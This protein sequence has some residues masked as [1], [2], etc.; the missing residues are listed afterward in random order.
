MF[1][2][3]PAHDLP[4]LVKTDVLLFFPP[5]KPCTH[6]SKMQCISDQRNNS[7]LEDT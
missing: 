6:F 5:F 3:L 1:I 2:I 4:F 7:G